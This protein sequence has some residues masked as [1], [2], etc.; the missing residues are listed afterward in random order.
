M[1]N[2][3][4]VQRFIARIKEILQLT[5]NMAPGFLQYISNGLKKVEMFVHKNI[6]IVTVLQLFSDIL[7]ILPSY[8][9]NK[10]FSPEKTK[11]KIK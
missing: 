3:R 6:G 2:F 1:V 9:Q 4:I 7:N 5:N 11:L 8:F 10:S